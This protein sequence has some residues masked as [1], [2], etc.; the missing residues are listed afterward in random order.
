MTFPV[1]IQAGFPCLMALIAG[2]GCSVPSAVEL[3]EADSFALNQLAGLGEPILSASQI[4]DRAQANGNLRE[5]SND[6]PLFSFMREV[7]ISKPGDNNSTKNTQTKTYRAFTNNRDQT[8]IK[9]NGRRPTSEEI[10]KDL[11]K[12]RK[13]QR[14]FLERD[15]K[16]GSEKMMSNNMDLYKEK[17]IPHLIGTE[18]I[19]DRPAYLIQLMP[20]TNHR[21]KNSTVDRIMNQMLTK[22]W[23]DQE[24]FQVSQ[25]EVELVKPIGIV[26][27]LVGSIKNIQI[28]LKQKRLTPQVWADLSIDADFDVRILTANFNFRMK[29]QSSGFKPVKAGKRSEE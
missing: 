9:V 13:R 15:S 3:I 18:M 22:L 12:N 25:I 23:V 29:S 11:E 19:G 14:R 28:R 6:L 21:I 17:F 8:L 1:N 7:K 26:V 4:V 5:T 10:E 16:Q 20:D 24:D 27:G 2:L